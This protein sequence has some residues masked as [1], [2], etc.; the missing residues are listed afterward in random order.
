MDKSKNP[1]GRPKVINGVSKKLIATLEEWK[2]IKELLQSIR[3][4]KHGK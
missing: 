2:E 4:S 3:A 1:V